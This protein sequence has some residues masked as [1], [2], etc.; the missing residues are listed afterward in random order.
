LLGV[1]V[2]FRHTAA[3]GHCASPV[4]STRAS[5]SA[6]TL[7]CGRVLTAQYVRVGVVKDVG[8][9]RGGGRSRVAVVRTRA[10]VCDVSVAICQKLV[11]S[12]HLEE[13]PASRESSFAWCLRPSLLQKKKNEEKH[14]HRC[15]SGTRLAL[16][17]GV[18]EAWQWRFWLC[19]SG[20]GTVGVGGNAGV[21]CLSSGH[22]PDHVMAHPA[23]N[24]TAGRGCR[25]ARRNCV[26]EPTKKTGCARVAS[27]D[28]TAACGTHRHTLLLNVVAHTVVALR[29]FPQPCVASSLFISF[30]TISLSLSLSQSPSLLHFLSLSSPSPLQTHSSMA[31]KSSGPT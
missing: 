1:L 24:S 9:A 2:R 5:D 17:F 26:V 18:A 20:K 22:S 25:C 29:R 4:N 16:A 3:N 21:F 12:A 30:V 6:R 7:R 19:F 13:V 10:C 15:L 28:W 27:E 31:P 23:G 14:H 8:V 11:R